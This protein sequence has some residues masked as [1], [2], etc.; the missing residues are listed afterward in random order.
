MFTKIV[1]LPRDIPTGGSAGLGSEHRLEPSRNHVHQRHRVSEGRSAQQT[2]KGQSALTTRN[3]S[4]T[5][6]SGSQW[7]RCVSRSDNL[8]DVACRSTV[9]RLMTWTPIRPKPKGWTG[10]RTLFVAMV[11]HSSFQFSVRNTARCFDVSVCDTVLSLQ[12]SSHIS[13]LVER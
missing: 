9:L 12:R 4:L 10:Q 6:T 2:G 13:H 3:A 5:G 1:D 11:V 8:L 7:K